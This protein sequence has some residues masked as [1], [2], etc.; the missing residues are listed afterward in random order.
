[1]FAARLTDLTTDEKRAEPAARALDPRLHRLAIEH[2]DFVWRSLRRLGITPPETDDATQQ[3]FLILS[4]KLSSVREGHERSYIVGIALRVAASVRRGRANARR[5]EIAEDDAPESLSPTATPEADLGRAEARA[6][7]DEVLAALPEDRRT[8]FVLFELEELS[9]PEIA[10]LLDL[11]IGTVAS[12][13]QRARE[14]FRAAIARLRAR[15]Q[16]V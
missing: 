10:D 14:D 11:P 5:R 1:M 8:V 13:L 9:K 15:R 12:R 4:R 2:Y 6:L 16:G 7:L 3:V